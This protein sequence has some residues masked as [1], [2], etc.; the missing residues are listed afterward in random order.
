[1]KFPHTTEICCLFNICLQSEKIEATKSL[2]FT[3][4]ECNLKLDAGWMEIMVHLVYIPAGQ[5]LPQVNALQWA[6]QL[7]DLPE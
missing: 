3:S 4:F 6:N 2:Q 5:L 7:A 1:M